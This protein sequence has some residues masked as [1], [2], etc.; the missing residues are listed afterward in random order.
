MRVGRGDSLFVIHDSR[1]TAYDTAG[2]V[3]R[4]M[5]F[6]SRLELPLDL[7]DVRDEGVIVSHLKQFSGADTLGLPLSVYD[8]SGRFVRAYGPLGVM[9]EFGESMELPRGVAL[10]GLRASAIS[11][12]GSIWLQDVN[13]RFE[14]VAAG[15]DIIRAYAVTTPPS[16]S[17][18]L[19]TV[20]GTIIA[21]SRKRTTSSA[22]PAGPQPV[23]DTARPVRRPTRPPRSSISGFAMLSDTIMV[24]LVLVASPDWAK[25]EGHYDPATLHFVEDSPRLLPGYRE[26]LH[27]TMVDIV[28]TST[29]QL[30]SRTR[31]SGLMRISSDG[32]LY[33]NTF[34][35]D[36]EIRVDAFALVP[37]L[38]QLL[39]RRGSVP[40]RP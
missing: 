3:A 16:W 6:E 20:S 28:N 38:G 23:P 8:T 35:S 40:R 22:P 11:P 1:L 9:G 30:L 29:G 25:A 13:Y 19:Y 24:V 39:R 12:D 17:M 32:T 33:R 36:G 14:N 34:R 18:P 37:N 10:H 5:R 31:V 7:V 27:D 21:Q 26:Q 2:N 15:G 4:A